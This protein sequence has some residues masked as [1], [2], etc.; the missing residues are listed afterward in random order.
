MY[1]DAA[2]GQDGSA[3]A[4]LMLSEREKT[5][6]AESVKRIDSAARAEEVTIALAIAWSPRRPCLQTCRHRVET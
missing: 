3:T 5:I 4:A 6:S 2:R 1:V